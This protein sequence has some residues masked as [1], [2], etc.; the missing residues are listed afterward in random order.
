LEG[1]II[2]VGGLYNPCFL[3]NDIL[4]YIDENIKQAITGKNPEI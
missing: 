3:I 1:F 4:T 2:P